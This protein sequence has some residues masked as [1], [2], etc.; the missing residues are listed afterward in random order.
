MPLRSLPIFVIGGQISNRR[1]LT[2]GFIPILRFFRV[3]A[4]ENVVLKRK[5]GKRRGG[6]IALIV[7][8]NLTFQVKESKPAFNQRLP[9]CGHLPNPKIALAELMFVDRCFGDLKS[10]KSTQANQTLKHCPQ[11]S[12]EVCPQRSDNSPS[13]RTELV[14]GYG[15]DLAGC[16]CTVGQLLAPS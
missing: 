3:T 9:S 15:E 2:C 14:P 4:V 5:G 7:L 10:T 12:M 1:F 13:S 16:K 11:L 8:K 6:T